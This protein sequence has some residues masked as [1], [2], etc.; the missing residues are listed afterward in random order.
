LVK[1]EPGTMVTPNVRL[2]RL[3]GRGAMGDVWLADHLGLKTRVAVKFVS[4]RVGPDDTEALERFTRE[5]ALA[6]QIKSS[7]VVQKFDHGVMEDGTP[8]IVMEYLEGEGLGE[9]LSRNKRL[10]LPEVAKIVWQTAKALNSAHK[11]GVVHRDIKPDN[12]FLSTRDD[13]LHVKVF[14]FGVAKFTQVPPAS[15]RPAEAPGAALGI[16]N[17]GVMIGTPEYMSPE[18]V[19]SSKAVDHFAD[20]WGLAVV[21]YVSL[22]ATLPFAGDDVGELCVRLLEGDF[23]PPTGIC[24]E[25]PVGLD[26]WFAKSFAKSRTDRFQSAREMAQAFMQVPGVAMGDSLTSLGYETLPVTGSDLAAGRVPSQ[27]DLLASARGSRAAT[28]SGAAA[29][30]ELLLPRR[31]RTSVVAAAVAAALAAAG[32]TALLMSSSDEAALEPTPAASTTAESA[33]ARTA[34]PPAEPPSIRATS[35]PSASASS[36]EESQRPARRARPAPPS[37]GRIDSHR[38]APQAPK[39]PGF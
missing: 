28:F 24:P 27:P 30:A 35:A 9:L 17:D 32:L 11:V 2:V 39:D 5:A 13:E 14:D 15:I 10:S 20:L 34:S 3:I 21:A 8:Y 33:P 31:R 6:A 25:L 18:Q 19:M 1:L 23:P 7:H 38:P 26:G 4:E 12:I 37:K 36:A 29:D 22:T 16:T